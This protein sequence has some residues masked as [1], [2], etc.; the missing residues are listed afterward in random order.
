MLFRVAENN[1]GIVATG[2]KQKLFQ[3]GFYEKI[4]HRTIHGPFLGHLLVSSYRLLTE[5]YGI[6]TRCYEPNNA[7]IVAL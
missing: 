1:A 5:R 7:K 3:F 6:T 4:F 2:H